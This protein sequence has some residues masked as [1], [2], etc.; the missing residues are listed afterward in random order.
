MIAYDDSA[1][2]EFLQNWR[3][4]RQP[5]YKPP[6][7]KRL[8]VDLSGKTSPGI[9]DLAEDMEFPRFDTRLAGK[10]ARYLYGASP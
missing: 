2:F 3:D 10:K 9:S 4:V 8:A 1:F 7:L 6:R 5:S